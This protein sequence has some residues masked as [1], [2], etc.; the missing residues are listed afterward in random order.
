MQEDFVTPGR[1][2]APKPR[3]LRGVMLGVLFAFLIGA[4]TVGWLAWRDGYDFGTGLLRK[5]AQPDRALAVAAPGAATPP[6]TATM[7]AQGTP[8]PLAV[9]DATQVAVDARIADLEGK[10]TRL[11]LQAQAA[12]GNTAR[13]EG[14]LVAFAARRATERGAPLGMLEDQ[15]KLRFGDAQPN[16]VATV[17]AMAHEPVTLSGLDAQL[18][19]LAPQ[20][21]GAPAG[22]SGWSRV[23]R[24]VT[25]LFI[26]R[27][28][29]APATA[30]QDRVER[31][32][33]LLREG[34]VDDAVNL[35]RQLPGSARAGGWMAAA[36]RY[37]D[38]QRAL[39][40]IE[41][42]AL[43]EPR[44]LQDSAGAKVD[45]PSPLTAPPIVLPPAQSSPQPSPGSAPQP[46]A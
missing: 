30:P 27:R 8:A 40:Q 3:S 41:T 37:A 20:I 46:A 43:L 10:L 25:G 24:E 33:L 21:V 17:I 7:A 2:A 39:D 34:R 19:G 9:S 32:R 1:A 14:L 18:L 28:D 13:A 44:R 45:Q 22:E 35:V 23:R 16:A 12:A 5:S 6:A 38:A 11:E 26:I 31:A 36:T 4:G 42:A 15:L 29:P